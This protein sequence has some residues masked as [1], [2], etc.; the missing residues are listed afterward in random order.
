VD[1]TREVENYL[2]VKRTLVDAMAREFR[3][4][5]GAKA[6]A[7]AVAPAF[8]RDQVL[9]YLAAVAVVDAARTGLREAGL[10]GVVGVWVTGIEPP[11]EA[12]LCLKGD[13]A[14]GVDPAALPGQVR[15]ALRDFHVTLDLPRDYPGGA[16]A[17]VVAD[18]EAGAA[19]DA[20]LADG[21]AVR[22]VRLK[23]RR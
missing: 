10:D 21:D 5:A 15:A 1:V 22:L 3:A 9:Q 12:R 2:G 13:P 23:P 11:R 14:D 18:A 19:V 6:L 20:L 16:G 17:G 8:S 7:R 4:G